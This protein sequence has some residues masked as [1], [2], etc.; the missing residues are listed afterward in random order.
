MDLWKR[1]VQSIQKKKKK[2]PK[3]KFSIIYSKHTAISYAAKELLELIKAESV[4]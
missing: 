4:Y 2:I 1:L 3:R